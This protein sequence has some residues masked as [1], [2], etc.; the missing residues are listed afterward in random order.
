MAPAPNGIK[1][2]YRMSDIVELL[3]RR[4]PLSTSG[5]ADEIGISRSTAHSYLSTMYD[6]GYVV[7]RPD[8]YDLSLK[9]LDVGVHVRDS[10][11]ITSVGEPVIEQL[12]QDTNEATWL[13][14]EE[15]GKAVYT[16]LALGDRAVHTRGRIG[17]RTY[18]HTLAAGKMILAHLPTERVEAII[19]EHGLPSQTEQTIDSR[20]ALYEELERVRE[21]GYALNDHESITGAR[22]VGAP[23]LVDDEVQGAVSVSGPAN[24]VTMERLEDEIIPALLAAVNELELKLDASNDIADRAR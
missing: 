19:E 11:P 2:L 10:L 13:I 15:H 1:S 5:V 14:V 12:A 7:T 23:V 20:E 9:F 3:M 18:L 22:A 4:G 8:G 21:Q 6:L 24:R 17:K 16:N